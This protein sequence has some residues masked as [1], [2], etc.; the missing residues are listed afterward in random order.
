MRAGHLAR[1]WGCAGPPASLSSVVRRFECLCFW[2]VR[3]RRD[4]VA[5][6]ESSARRAA[7]DRALHGRREPVPGCFGALGYDHDWL[8]RETPNKALQATAAAL[9]DLRLS[10]ESV[11]VVADASALPAAVP[12]LFR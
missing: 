11:V 4:G 1:R 2:L 8:R 3:L 6:F 10:L 12:E 5:R 9:T 7:R